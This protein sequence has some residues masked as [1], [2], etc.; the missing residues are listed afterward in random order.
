M[1][2]GISTERRDRDDGTERQERVPDLSN[3]TGVRGFPADLARSLGFPAE[4]DEVIGVSSRIRPKPALGRFGLDRSA[5]DGLVI[6][7]GFD[8]CYGLELTGFFV[9]IVWGIIFF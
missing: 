2:D 8:D 5:A 1:G 3:H 7:V 9:L 4:S 6:G